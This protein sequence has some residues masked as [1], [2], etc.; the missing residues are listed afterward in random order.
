MRWIAGSLIIGLTGWGCGALRAEEKP[1]GIPIIEEDPDED[2]DPTNP[3]PYP[4]ELTVKPK[5]KPNPNFPE[6]TVAE[7]SPLPRLDFIFSPDLSK[8]VEK[9][10]PF[11]SVLDLPKGP[12]TEP[13]KLAPAP[14]GPVIE[15][16]TD[17]DTDLT[18]KEGFELDRKAAGAALQEGAK[19]MQQ[20]LFADALAKFEEALTRLPDNHALLWNAGQ[21]AYGAANFGTAIDYWKHLKELEPNSGRIRFKLI[22]AYQAGSQLK[23]RD[24][25][26]LEL[27]NLYL[28]SKMDSLKRLACYCREQFQ[29]GGRKIRAY[30]FFDPTKSSG[31]RYEFLVQNSLDQT[32]SKVQ[33]VESESANATAR[34]LGELKSGAKLFE[35]TAAYPDKQALIHF[36]RSEPEYDKV[37]AKLIDL[38]SA[39]LTPLAELDAPTNEKWAQPDND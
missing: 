11:V 6:V 3:L 12:K 35:M 14:A 15:T 24:E 31:L 9:P 34:E 20:R 19:L 5:A 1:H 21:A 13:I 32:E 27:L 22:Q 16:N 29:A 8:P 25:E 38:L 36:Y 23:E 39:K 2:V 17:Q 10:K 37:R 7:F 33:V 4:I 30:E 28:N 18:V 26:R